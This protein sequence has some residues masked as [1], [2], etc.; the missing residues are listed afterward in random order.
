MTAREDNDDTRP[1]APPPVEVPWRELTP[2]ALRGVAEA[3]VLRE[4]TD[5][6]AV[7]TSFA[8][9][10]AEV[11]RQ[12]ERGEAVIYYEP[13]SR[14]VELVAQHALPGARAPRDRGD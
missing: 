13:A 8:D 1:E 5:Y 4:G 10:V 2:A 9:K 14:S 11:M 6:G 12:L 7:E 3:F